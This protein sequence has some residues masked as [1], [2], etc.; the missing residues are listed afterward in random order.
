MTDNIASFLRKEAQEKRKRLI[1][2]IGPGPGLLT[3]SLLSMPSTQRLVCI[4]KDL[5]FKPILSVWNI[6]YFSN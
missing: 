1:V 2:E 6:L 4:E 5:R 3:R